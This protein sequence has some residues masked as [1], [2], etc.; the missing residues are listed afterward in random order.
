MAS[1]DRISL[2]EVLENLEND[3]FDDLVAE[4]SDDNLGMDT[5]YSNCCDSDNFRQRYVHVLCD[6]EKVYVHRRQACMYAWIHI[7]Q[8]VNWVHWYI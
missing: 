7:V 4:G 1:G 5:D 8:K 3:D 2:S 6:I